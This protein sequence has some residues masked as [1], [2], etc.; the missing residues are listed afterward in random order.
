MLHIKEATNKKRYFDEIS[1]KFILSTLPL[2]ISIRRR[3]R[4]ACSIPEKGTLRH[5]A[6]RF[7]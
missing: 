3:G 2:N 4:I 7:I 6:L 5:L 1:A